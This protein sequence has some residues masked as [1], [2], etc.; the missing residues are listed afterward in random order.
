ML[1]ALVQISACVVLRLNQLCSYLVISY[2]ID[3][4]IDFGSLYL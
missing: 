1:Y 3:A 2:Y 4:G